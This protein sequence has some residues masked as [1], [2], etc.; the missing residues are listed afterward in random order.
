MGTACKEKQYIMQRNCQN[1]AYFGDGTCNYWSIEDH[2]RPCPPGDA[3]TVKQT[4]QQMRQELKKRLRKRAAIP[5]ASRQK[6]QK[7]NAEVKKQ[8]G[9][10][11]KQYVVRNVQNGEKIVCG[12]AKTCAEALQIKVSSFRWAYRAYRAGSYTKYD[13]KEEDEA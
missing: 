13:I 5:A 12:S 4:S 8:L 2:M 10:P 7:G 1:C 3:C 6:K 11:S 9:R